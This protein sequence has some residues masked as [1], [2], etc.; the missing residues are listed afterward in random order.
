MRLFPIVIIPEWDYF[1]TKSDTHVVVH[2][3]QKYIETDA[4]SRPPGAKVVTVEQGKEPDPFTKHF[5]KW[6]KAYK[7]STATY[8]KSW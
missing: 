1:L 5:P 8:L 2:D 4:T 3:F 7:V 6:S